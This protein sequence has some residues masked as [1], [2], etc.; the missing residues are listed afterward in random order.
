MSGKPIGAIACGHPQ[1]AQA[2]QSVLTDGGN[3]FDAVVAAHFTACIAEPVLASLAGGGFLLA[4]T[5]DG[6]DLLYDFFAHTPRRQRAADDV[7]FYPISADFGTTSQEFHIGLG[8]AATPGAVRGMFDIQRDLCTLPMTR[9][10]EPAVEAARHGI[11]LNALQAYIFDVIKPIYLSTPGAAAIFASPA[12]PGCLVGEHEVLRQGQQADVLEALAR[13]G[14]ALFY[15]GELARLVADMC[16]QGGG[17]INLDDLA[18]YRVLKRTPLEFDYRGT[19]I[20]TNPAPSSGGVLIAFALKLLEAFSPQDYGF[21]SL[22]MTRLLADIMAATNRARNDTHLDE[23]S[24]PHAARLLDDA[25]VSGYLAGV[26][27][28][29]H[30]S[31]GTTHISVADAD[32]NIA[33]LTVSNG[34]G[35]GHIIPDT[36]IMLNNMLGEEDLNP[37]GFHRW[38]CDRRMTSMM[39]PTIVSAANGHYTA[40][41]SGGSNRLRTAIL[42]VL[43]NLIDFGMPLADAVDAPRIHFERDVLNIEQAT[44]RDHL[45]ALRSDYPQLRCWDSRN[46]FFGGVHSVQAGKAAFSGAG[47]PRRGGVARIVR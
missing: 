35:C 47:D 27:H 11:A 21:G 13:E 40:L 45:D 9:L 46:L 5:A 14:D 16:Q 41:G 44:E 22:A 29:A 20:L 2:A 19:R 3:A 10:V 12:A 18:N 23:Q 33:S 28:D 24:H 30:C 4:R 36:G 37:A 26:R 17:H 32:G 38:P 1:T 6:R 25:Y 31:R 34:E 43:V 7:D 8:A 15:E 39:A 42:Q